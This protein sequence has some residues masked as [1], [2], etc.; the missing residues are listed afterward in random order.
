MKGVYILDS[1]VKGYERFLIANPGELPTFVREKVR[2]VIS[3]VE[4]SDGEVDG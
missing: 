2:A 4:V 1:L 3:E